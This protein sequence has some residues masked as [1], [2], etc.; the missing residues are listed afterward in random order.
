MHKLAITLAVSMTLGL[1]AAAGASLPV[2]G[3][4]AGKTSLKPI[5]GFVDIVTFN[6]AKK[7]TVLTKFVFGTLGCFGTSSFP[8]GTDPY[9]EA[10][11]TATV[12][13]SIP[14]TKKGTFLITTKPT[15]ADPEG[16]V[17]TA[18]IQGSVV[19]SKSIAGT[20]TVSQSDKG[21]TCGPSK[22]KFTAMPGT[23]S[24]LGIGP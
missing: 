13:G 16:V 24:S 17:T 12:K 15:L 22:M 23:P 21:D 4:F 10:E 14:V 1:A 2:A 5:N 8:V 3:A 7:G 11:N 20:I 19:N 18:V 6:S 9:G